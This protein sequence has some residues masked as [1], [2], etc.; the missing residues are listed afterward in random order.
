MLTAR[1]SA[2]AAQATSARAARAWG[3]ALATFVGTRLERSEAYLDQPKYI[4]FRAGRWVL[5]FDF[6]LPALFRLNAEILHSTMHV[7]RSENMPE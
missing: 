6:A 1:R 7:S 4:T 3:I 5:V 2:R